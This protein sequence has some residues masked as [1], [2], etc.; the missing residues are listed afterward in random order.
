[1][2][3]R[4]GGKSCILKSFCS[5]PGGDQATACVVCWGRPHITA[6]GGLNGSCVLSQSSGQTS[7]TEV[8][9]GQCSLRGLEWAILPCLFQ[10]LVVLRHSLAC[11]SVPPSLPPW[12]RGHLLLLPAPHST[13]L[14]L[15]RLLVRA[16]AHDLIFLNDLFPNRV[17]YGD[18]RWM[19]IWGTQFSPRPRVR[20]E[21]KVVDE[22]AVG[23]ES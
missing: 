16:P 23:Q 14:C 21:W 3:G 19:C 17:S 8:S 18:P 2:S 9:P 10:L 6:S 1:M 20:G 12:S 4:A 13:C 22:S 11:D 5:S 15:T 7:K